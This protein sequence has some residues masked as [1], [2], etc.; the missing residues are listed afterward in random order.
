MKTIALSNYPPE[1]LELLLEAARR[2]KEVLAVVELK[3]RFDEEANIEWARRF[4]AAME[5]W[6]TGGAY[7]NFLGDVDQ[8]GAARRIQIQR[9]T[10][11]LGALADANRSPVDHACDGQSVVALPFRTWDCRDAERFRAQWRTAHASR[12]AGLAGLLRSVPVLAS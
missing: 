12:I 2:G 5:P 7:V 6:S 4:I 3:A 9:T 1:T 11:G 8:A 10:V